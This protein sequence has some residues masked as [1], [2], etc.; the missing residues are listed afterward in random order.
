M[1]CV[2]HCVLLKLKQNTGRDEINLII[3]GIKKLQETV[4]DIL[5][6]RCGKQ[7]ESVDDG[8][9]ATVAAVVDFKSEEAYKVYAKHPSHISVIKDVILPH[10]EPSGRSAIQF[11]IS[12]ADIPGASDANQLTHIV[13][14]KLKNDTMQS[15]VDEMVTSLQ[16]LGLKATPLV[17]RMACGAQITSVDDG[18]N[19]TV[20]AV[21][22]FDSNE[23]FTKY[24]EHPK[25][26]KVIRDFIK[27][28][29]ERRTGIQFR[30]DSGQG[31]SG[32]G[33]DYPKA[34]ATFVILPLIG[35]II[36]R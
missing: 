15:S 24:W 1:V 14:L 10:L 12:E 19:A 26:Q 30:S 13:L 23:D 11:P 16:T 20:G 27:P 28:H 29:L 33:W 21:V 5:S 3:E 34:F 7:V 25:H 17:K 22:T 9:N 31:G 8:R 2:R 36:R 4:P 6:L 35:S 32:G 18:R